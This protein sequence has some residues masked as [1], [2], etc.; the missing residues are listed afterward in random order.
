MLRAMVQQ[1]QVEVSRGSEWRAPGDTLAPTPGQR[2][3]RALRRAIGAL[4]LVFYFTMAPIGYAA[5][6]ALALLPTR[7]PQRRAR[8]LQA[9][10]RV[11]FS[12]L[13]H[14]MRWTRI[15]RFDPRHVGGAALPDGPCVLVANHP[16]LT[17]VTAI[18]ASVGGVSTIVK[19]SIYRRW[20]LRPLLASAGQFESVASD[21][22]ALDDT[23][24]AA[25][26]QLEA[27]ARVLIFP[28]GTRSP[29]GVLGRIGRTPFELACRANVPVVPIVIR[30]EPVYLGKGGGLLRMPY[31][32]PR[33][34][35]TVLASVAPKDYDGDSRA[36]KGAIEAAYKE[37][38]R[39][40][41]VR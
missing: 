28:E 21:P 7:A 30:C 34:T 4:T 9:I 27:G 36:L 37:S 14:W 18:M 22:L 31:R 8:T 12:G 38:A 1:A 24:A 25:G 35:L 17:D 11:A 13:H 40:Q 5:F 16:T 19:S 33:M 39:S 15:L 3:G 26:A 29:G 10:F 2:L 23:L 20:W 6:M 41:S 32:V